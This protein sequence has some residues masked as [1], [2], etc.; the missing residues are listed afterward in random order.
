MKEASDAD[1]PAIDYRESH[2]DPTKPATYDPKFFEPG[3][4]LN[5]FWE[6]ER[7]ILDEIVAGMSSPPA[8]ALD[9]ACGTGRVLSHVATLAP[10]VV[11]VDVS[12]PMLELARARCPSAKIVEA[13]LT[14]DPSP[15]A[16]RFDLITAFRFFLNAQND[17]RAGV[18]GALRELLTDRGLLVANFHLNPRSLT[19]VYIRTM[20]RIRGRPQPLV[21]GLG[22]ALRL[23]RTNGFDPV[24]VRGYGYLLHRTQHVPLAPVLS[25]LERGLA[26]WNPAPGTALNFIVAARPVRPGGD[27]GE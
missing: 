9:F 21:I 20:S 27:A 15:V 2:R 6:I 13:D 17:L 10:E 8:R 19:G 12:A 26:R 1:T 25:P 7:G 18:L 23:L 3:H 24:A 16:G 11:G 4:T 5:L 22:E 14:V